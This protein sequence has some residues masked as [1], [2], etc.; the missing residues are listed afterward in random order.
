ME[1][2]ISLIAKAALISD[3]AEMFVDAKDDQHK[4]GGDP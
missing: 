4:L 3:R 1:F 2:A